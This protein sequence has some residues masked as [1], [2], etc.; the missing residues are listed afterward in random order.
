MSRVSNSIMKISSLTYISVGI[1]GMLGASLR[2]FISIWVQDTFSLFPWATF[3]I[4]L[5]VAFLLSFLLF[6]P[7]TTEKLPPFSLTRVP[8]GLLV[9]YSTYSTFTL[10]MIP[11]AES[12]PLITFT[13]MFFSIIRGLGCSFIGY[14]LARL[15]PKGGHRS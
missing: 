14:K 6:L 4:N 10:E 12:H 3:T 5:T 1:G 2:Y 11:L 13:Y 9:A 8:T 7:I 15:I